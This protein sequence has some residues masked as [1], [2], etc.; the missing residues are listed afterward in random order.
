[1]DLLRVK[2]IRRLQTLHQL[3]TEVPDINNLGNL[4]SLEQQLKALQLDVVLAQF[5]HSK[6]GSFPMAPVFMIVPI[7]KRDVLQ[8]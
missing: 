7:V 1:V 5:W 8:L 3:H 4:L 6:N 2:N